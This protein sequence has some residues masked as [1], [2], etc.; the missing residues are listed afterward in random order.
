MPNLLH[1]LVLGVIEGLTEFLPVSSTAHLILAS[2]FLGLETSEFL[3]SFE[4]VIQ[5]GAI[6]A[7]LVIYGRKLLQSS[8]LWGRIAAAFLPTAVVG[9]LFYKIIKTYLL[10]SVSLVSWTLGLGGL[11]IIIFELWYRRR[12]PEEGNLEQITYRQ[13]LLVGCAQSLAIVPGVSRA[14]AT[15]LGG[16]ALGLPRRTIVEFSFL[17]ALPTVAAATGLDLIKN[18][19][20]FSLDQFGTL[21]VG[22]LSSF[23]VAYLAIKYFLRYIQQHDFTGFGVY[24]IALA[25]LAIMSL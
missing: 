15:I 21:A 7:V 23:L 1:A 6:L 16:L 5:L 25:L 20:A 19:S 13:A 24:R 3:K 10:A 18:A 9:L 14:A 11:A 8:E 12:S 2:H 22:F 17:L 4:I